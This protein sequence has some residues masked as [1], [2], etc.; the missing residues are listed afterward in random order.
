MHE[1]TF[2][3]LVNE[4]FFK[5]MLPDKDAFLVGDLPGGESGTVEVDLCGCAGGVGEDGLVALVRDW[6]DEGMGVEKWFR[7]D[8]VNVG[9]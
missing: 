7:E 3:H 2:F 5:R 6:H 1:L 9:V 8:G 4:E